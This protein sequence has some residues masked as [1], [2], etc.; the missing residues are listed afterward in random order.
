[1]YNIEDTFTYLYKLYV[2]GNAYLVWVS[3]KATP[4]GSIINH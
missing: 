3:Q 4:P 2:A 1:M